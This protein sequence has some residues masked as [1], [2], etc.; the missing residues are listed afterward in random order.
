[1][2]KYLPSLNTVYSTFAITIVATTAATLT[3]LLNKVLKPLFKQIINRAKKL[4]GKKS[5]TK[6]SSS[7]RLKK[8]KLL[9][10]NVDD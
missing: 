3:P 8:Q 4:I 9:S 7:S 6:F 5:G 2:E 1:M 10:K